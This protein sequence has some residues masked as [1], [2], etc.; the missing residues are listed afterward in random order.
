MQQS[1]NIIS[2]SNETQIFMQMLS[3]S[4]TT[5]KIWPLELTQFFM[6]QAEC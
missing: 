5:F 6:N 3:Y 2:V 1:L 4:I